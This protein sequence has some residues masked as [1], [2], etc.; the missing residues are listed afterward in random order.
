M[1]GRT[2]RIVSGTA[3]SAGVKPCFPPSRPDWKSGLGPYKSPQ[4]RHP[5]LAIFL[6][7]QDRN[8]RYRRGA[9]TRPPAPSA[10]LH[11]ASPP[12]GIDGNTPIRRASPPTHFERVEPVM[13]TASWPAAGRDL[14]LTLLAAQRA[15]RTSAALSRSRHL[16]TRFS[17][18]RECF[19]FPFASTAWTA[20]GPQP[21]EVRL[22][23]SEDQGLKWRAEARVKPEQQS[24]GFRAPHDGEYWFSIRTID[25]QGH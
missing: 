1:P 10:R 13:K 7:R 19:R 18:D 4:L 6:K 8:G 25:R 23:V 16:A 20:S 9:V 5:L 14:M 17:R 22:F 2:L 3:C 24:F 11:R 21:A 15:N 12:P